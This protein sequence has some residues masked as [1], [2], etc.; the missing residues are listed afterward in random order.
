MNQ[1]CKM[2][3]CYRACANIQVTIAYAK[4]FFIIS[5]HF[6]RVKEEGGW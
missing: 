3:F 5:L 4:Q 2:G 6:P 1:L